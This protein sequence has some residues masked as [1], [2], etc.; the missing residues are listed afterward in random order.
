[1][2]RRA[3]SAGLGTAALCALNSTLL[4]SPL[5]SQLKLE[6]SACDDGRIDGREAQRTVR[7]ELEADGVSQIVDPQQ[8]PEPDLSLSIDIGCDSELT[9]RVILQSS[10]TG[11]ERQRRIV[12]ADADST[13]RARA[14]AL[15]VSEFV[16]SDWSY[17]NEGEPSGGGDA[18]AVDSDGHAENGRSAPSK[19]D[20]DAG[21][22]L[23][24][25]NAAARKPAPS[26]AAQFVP[27]V[28]RAPRDA[29]PGER[30]DDDG[31][32][33]PR[34]PR[35]LALAGNA[36]VRWFTDYASLDVGGDVGTDLGALRLRAE[37]L[38]TSS[39]DALGTASLGSAALCIGYR[40]FAKQLGPF[41]IAGYPL[42]SAGVTWM[43]GSPATPSVR[44]DPLTG[45]YADLRFVLES[46]L[47]ASALSPSLAAEVGRASGLVARAGDRTLGATGGFFLGA[48][49]GARY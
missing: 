6:V 32:G 47:V 21:H 9:T 17:L 30:S 35:K 24:A 31:D 29:A 10:R 40:V 26:P 19:S 42:V 11:R 34:R 23:G 5:P 27:P 4:A 45:P 41:A 37:G 39:Q 1:M 28:T 36:R 20:G 49:A 18:R 7:S 25:T 22:A 46:R 44:I 38:V 13:A 15:A 16:R 48:S 14:L 33:S 2:A 8:L 3:L 12:L 43:R